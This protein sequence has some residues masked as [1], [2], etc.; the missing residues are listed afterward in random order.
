MTG[1]GVERLASRA[2]PAAGGRVGWVR[3]MA[4]MARVWACLWGAWSGS[5]SGVGAARAE[6]TAA[7]V[8]LG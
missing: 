5:L 2:G 4:A 7:L 1:D 6:V 8:S 3:R